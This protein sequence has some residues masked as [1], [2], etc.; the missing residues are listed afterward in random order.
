LSRSATLFQGFGLG[1]SSIFISP[2]DIEGV[3]ITSLGVPIFTVSVARKYGRFDQ[4][5]EKTS[6]LRTLPTIFPR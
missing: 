6:A 1:C 5:L 4:Y 2:T 3:I